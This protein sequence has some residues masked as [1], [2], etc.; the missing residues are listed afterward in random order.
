MI[1]SGQLI[2]EVIDALRLTLLTSSLR[3]VEP[4]YSCDLQCDQSQLGA[5][6]GVLSKRRGV[7]DREDVIE[8]TTLFL[9]TGIG[10]VQ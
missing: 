6:Y 1:Y 7:V 5:L 3:V 4:L 8:G 9:L 2:S 10:S